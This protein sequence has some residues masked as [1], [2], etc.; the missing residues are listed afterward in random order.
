MR[1]AVLGTGGV[2][3]YFGGRLHEAGHPVAFLARGAH[4]SAL[5]TDGLRLE[6]LTGDLQ[7]SPVTATDNP[8]EVG[9]VDCVLVA[10]KAWQLP[11]A[12][13]SLG[14]LMGPETVVLPLLNGV[15][16]VDAIA[17]AVGR[18]HVLGGVAWIRS[19]IAGP[20]RIRHAGVDPRIAVGEPAGGLSPRVEALAAA[21]RE[22]GL[23]TEASADIQSVLW[24]KLVFIAPTSALGAATR[25][26]I[27][28]FRAVPETRAVMIAAMEE[29]VAVGRARGVALAQDVVGKTVSWVDGLSAGS[30][31]SMHRDVV[32]GRP[33]ELET[34]VGAVVRLG[35][36]AGVPTPV[37][38]VLYA[39]LLPQE[40]AA[41]RAAGLEDRPQDP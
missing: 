40:Q 32:A 37:S 21:F 34:Q 3:G 18:H 35:R 2:G 28:V 13:P 38:A 20:G 7:L 6:S 41:R 26:T 23:R 36:Q 4:L 30:T 17:A 39:A 22:A 11:A 24:A 25:S 10:V 16:A 14:P 31:S 29:A 19:E 12:L 27:D 33:S 9:P 15:E 8:A 1:I 5:R